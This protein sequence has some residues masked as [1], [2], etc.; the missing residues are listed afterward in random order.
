MPSFRQVLLGTAGFLALAYLVA[1]FI[2]GAWRVGDHRGPRIY[3][4]ALHE[5]C[6]R[7]GGGTTAAEAG[8][9][10][11]FYGMKAGS[12]LRT[13]FDAPRGRVTK[14]N[15]EEAL[16]RMEEEGRVEKRDK[17]R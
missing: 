4:Q 16:Q 3:P 5:A 14:D 8:P 17:K 2:A 6:Y 1:P 10:P 11:W 15:A 12:L 7:M 13:G 9:R